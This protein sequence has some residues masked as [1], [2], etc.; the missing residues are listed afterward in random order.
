MLLAKKTFQEADHVIQPVQ[1][2]VGDSR[3]S[4]GAGQKSK[5][6]ECDT[7]LPV[8]NEELNQGQEGKQG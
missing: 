6:H 8:S 1:Q 7:V 3:Q 5:H 2:Q 4:D